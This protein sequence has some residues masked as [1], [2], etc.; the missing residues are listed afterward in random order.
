MLISPEDGRK[1]DVGASPPEVP[2]TE[3][4]SPSVSPQDQIT[5]RREQNLARLQGIIE[6][7]V[8][9]D[10]PRDR[11]LKEWEPDKL[12]TTAIQ[13]ILDRSA[14]VPVAVIAEKYNYNASYV[15]VLMNH[16]DAQTLMTTILSMSADR[17]TDIDERL[18]HL[19]PEAM[20]VKVELMRNSRLDTIR[21]KAASD[22]LDMAGY[23]KKRSE[24]K[25][26][27]GGTTVINSGPTFIMPAQAAT[28]LLKVLEEANQVKGMSYDGFLAGSRK[29]E[30]IVEH[31]QLGDSLKLSPGQTLAEE[32][33]SPF[34][35]S[36]PEEADTVD[37]VAEKF[38]V[39]GREAE[40]MRNSLLDES[41]A[42][43]AAKK[44]KTA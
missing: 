24:V 36:E 26:G 3:A 1:L 43:E 2:G 41:E 7:A 39:V 5:R 27:N 4:S 37:A 44:R 25:T 15:S 31:K 38:G 33:A 19:A 22:I 16:P 20:N 40:E 23:G 32:G 42:R 17:V 11:E 6:A 30:V 29:D 8:R 12:S 14:G 13:A 21:D 28:G 18:K 9:G 10:L 35:P 34:P